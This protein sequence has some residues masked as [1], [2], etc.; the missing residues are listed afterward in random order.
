MPRGRI[1]SMIRGTAGRDNFDRDHLDDSP[2]DTSHERGI[3]GRYGAHRPRGT[4]ARAFDHS[5]GSR[6]EFSHYASGASRGYGGHRAAGGAG[7]D[8]D[9]DASDDDTV[10]GM[11]NGPRSGG[12]RGHRGTLGEDYASFDDDSF[13]GVSS[14]SRFGGARGSRG[15]GSSDRYGGG[16]HYADD[17]DF[18]GQPS[19]E[20]D[21]SYCPP[22][23]GRRGAAASARRGYDSHPVDYDVQSPISRRHEI[24]SHPRHSGM[25]SRRRAGTLGEPADSLGADRSFVSSVGGYSAGGYETGLGGRDSGARHYGSQRG[26]GSFGGY[27]GGREL[28]RRY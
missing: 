17:S 15:Y 5:A 28:G 22:P 1:N 10:T 8:S 26:L 4:D 20:D 16:S 25:H 7:Y 24:S 3:S 2:F 19:D 23:R 6:D 12:A 27:E 18:A 14:R 13:A 9:D 21:E 11:V